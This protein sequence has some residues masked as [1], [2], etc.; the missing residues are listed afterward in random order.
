MLTTNEIAKLQVLMAKADID[1][2]Q[3]IADMFNATR[4]MKVNSLKNNFK[5]GQK[6]TWTGKRG[7]QEGVITKIN[8]KNIVVN[9]GPGGMWNVSPALLTVA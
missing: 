9:A 2:F 5:V 3:H 7:F 8:R 1:Q 4:R 6:V